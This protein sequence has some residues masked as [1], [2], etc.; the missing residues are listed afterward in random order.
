MELM[1]KKQFLKYKKAAKRESKEDRQLAKARRLAAA[2]M[3]ESEAE[4]D[5]HDEQLPE[6]IDMSLT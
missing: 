5:K 1:A 3:A 2:L 4:E 6:I